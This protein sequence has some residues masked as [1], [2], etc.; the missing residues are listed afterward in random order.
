MYPKPFEMRRKL[1]MLLTAMYFRKHERAQT[2]KR[3]NDDYSIKQGN[4]R[5]AKKNSFKRKPHTSQF[6]RNFDFKILRRKKVT[7]FGSVF[8]CMIC[9]IK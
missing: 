8:K 3:I 1:A 7:V 5:I 9:F 6:G 2:K 4:Q